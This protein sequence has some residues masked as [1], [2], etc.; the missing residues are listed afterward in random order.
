MSNGGPG[1]ALDA[2]FKR[3]LYFGLARFLLDLPRIDLMKSERRHELQQNELAAY[4]GRLNRSIEPY[5]KLIAVLLAVVIIGGIAIGLYNNNASEQR[6]DATLQLIQASGSG[7]PEV[8]AKVGDDF[9]ETAAGAWARL[10]QANEYLADGMRLLYTGGAAEDMLDQAIDAFNQAIA[11]S[12]N[13]LLTSRA[14]FGIARAEE[15]LGEIDA[16]I[17]AYEKT[18]AVNESEAMVK[19]AQA[20]IDSLSSPET[21]QFLA[22]FDE[23]D[24][25]PADPSLPP[26]LPSGTALPELPDLTLPDLGGASDEAKD[27]DQ[28]IGM[29][30]QPAASEDGSDEADSISDNPLIL[31][32]QPV[33]EE[34][35]EPAATEDAESPSEDATSPSEDAA[36]PSEDATPEP[37]QSEPESD[38]PN[39]PEDGGESSADAQPESGNAE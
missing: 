37:A 29:P 12:D 32:N 22:W 25:S 21:K 20:R 2:K 28:G 35:S 11:M 3:F 23:Q 14:Y 5:S 27:P 39:D 9:P 7:D 18:I 8:L 13:R 10:Y 19:R 33:V 16:A 1:H 34:V 36:P 15:S 38:P 30:Q 31:P 26:S 24:F 4:L 6:S 17:E